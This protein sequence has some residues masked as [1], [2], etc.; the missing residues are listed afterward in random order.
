MAYLSYELFHCCS[1]GKCTDRA[2]VVLRD[3]MN[4]SR[5]Q[6]CRACGKLALR[7][8]QRW[9]ATHNRDGSVRDKE[10]KR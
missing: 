1:A 4:E 5:G 6:Y 7:D 10:N 2:V 8:R 3:W 9:E